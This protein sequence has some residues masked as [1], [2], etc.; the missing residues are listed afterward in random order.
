MKAMQ[1]VR[2]NGFMAARQPA[3]ECDGSLPDLSRL[4]GALL[5]WNGASEGLYLDA[6]EKLRNVHGRISQVREGIQR[7]TELFAAAEMEEMRVGLASAVDDARRIGELTAERGGTLA[8]LR[9]AIAE[10]S[11]GSA[12]VRLVF[13]LLDYVVLIARAQVEGMRSGQDELVPFTLHV[14][15]LVTSGEDVARYIDGRM[16]LLGGYLEEGRTL[17][18]QAVAS[19]TGATMVEGFLRLASQMENQQRSAAMR[20]EEAQQAFTAVWKAIGGVV[21]GLQFH[22]MARQRLEHTISN[23]DLLNRIANDGVVAE[24]EGPLR[25]HIRP[26][27]LRRIATLEIAQL[28]GLAETYETKLAGLDADLAVIEAELETCGAILGRLL[29]GGGEEDGLAMLDAEASRMRVGFRRGEAIRQR[30]GESLGRSMEATNSLFEMTEKLADLEHNLRIA[31]FNAAVR[32]AHV[33]SGDDTIGYI[34][35]VI[36]EQASKAREEA[37]K[38]QRGIEFAITT[39][40][41][42]ASRILPAIASAESAIEERLSSATTLLSRTEGQ[43]RDIIGKA[44]ALAR[45]LGQ[46]IG[47]VRAL[48]DS[49]V[50]GREMMLALSAGLAALAAHFPEADLPPEDAERLGRALSAH[51]TM[52]EERAIFQ[53]VMGTLP[54]A[55]GGTDAAAPPA[56]SA[57][58]LDDILF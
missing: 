50:E 32:A 19:G 33:D 3:G 47:T 13:R 48:M 40:G 25:D 12:A 58:D 7:S 21:M 45:G 56:G 37:D 52:E 28:C 49:H 1:S 2:E 36:R 42:L 20:R 22:D 38:V 57:D 51:Y 35:R 14:D 53:E 8:D 30:L 26:A 34:A 4:A 31:G 54:G 23:L 9:S 15:E 55:A 16:K 18:A 11:S 44:I 17:E 27:A 24:G 43:C 46:E 29:S 41:S 5:R 10:A 6:G 39:T